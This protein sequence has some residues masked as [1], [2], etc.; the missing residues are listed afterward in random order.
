[1]L[2]RCRQE[3][4]EEFYPVFEED[5]C[6][7]LSTPATGPHIDRLLNVA[8]GVG[9]QPDTCTEFT[10][11]YMQFLATCTRAEDKLVRLRACSLM[12]QVYNALCLTSC[13]TYHTDPHTVINVAAKR[14][15]IIA[16][17]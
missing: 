12:A 7:I 8:A 5:L 17:T 9:I 1:M 6:R 15:G 3:H 13:G 14:E 11:Q 16:M 2:S 10:D 4:V